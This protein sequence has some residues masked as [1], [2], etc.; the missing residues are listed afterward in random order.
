MWPCR[1]TYQEDLLGEFYRMRRLYTKNNSKKLSYLLRHDHS[2][3]FEIGG[4]RELTELCL[5]H[6][7]TVEEVVDIVSNDDKGRFEFNPDKTKVR[8]LYGHSVDVDLLLHKQEPPLHLLH[9]TALKYIESIRNNG[10]KSK[11]R[12]YVHLTEDRDLALRT[13]SRHGLAV[14]LVIDAKSMFNDG[15]SFYCSKNGTWLTSEVPLQYIDFG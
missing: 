14:L 12:Q 6:S 2:Y 5:L 9:G 1:K 15:Y 4:W 3:A 10:L 7:F 13:G 8:A 11:A